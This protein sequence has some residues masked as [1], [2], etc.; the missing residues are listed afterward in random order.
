MLPVP[1]LWS[2]HHSLLN[3]AL[4]RPQKFPDNEKFRS[5]LKKFASSLTL[6]QM[7]NWHAHPQMTYERC[8]T[9]MEAYVQPL[10]RGAVNKSE[11]IFE[12]EQSPSSISS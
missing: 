6:D 9:N 4:S 7:I 12:M 2:R 10:C 3:K 5:D 1:Y 11:S 8:I